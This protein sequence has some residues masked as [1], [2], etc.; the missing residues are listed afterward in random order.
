MTPSR[1]GW[2]GGPPRN[3]VALIDRHGELGYVYSKVH[4]CVW[5]ADEVRLFHSCVCT[6][7]RAMR[8]S[9]A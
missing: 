6:L 2:G 7:V 5:A 8:A 3:S 4:T 1:K 9:S